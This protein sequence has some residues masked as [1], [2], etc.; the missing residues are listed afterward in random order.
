M[1]KS[2]SVTSSPAVVRSLE[3]IE[4]SLPSS[5]IPVLGSHLVSVS[6]NGDLASRSAAHLFI[7]YDSIC[8]TCSLTGTA[9]GTCAR[10]V[11]LQQSWVW[12][13]SIN[14]TFI[15]YRVNSLHA[16]S[17]FSH[18]LMTYANSLDP[19]QAPHCVG[20]DLRFKLFDLIIQFLQKSD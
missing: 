5:T 7:E 13:R 1:N 9:D 14:Y 16:S 17:R 18:P 15:N 3:E 2:G 11:S 19:N 8:H 10:E 4:C 12:I 6:N 20:S